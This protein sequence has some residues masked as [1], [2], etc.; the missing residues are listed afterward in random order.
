MLEM[1]ESLKKKCLNYYFIK[2][3]S[4]HETFYK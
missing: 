4:Q 2:T 1:S 3:L